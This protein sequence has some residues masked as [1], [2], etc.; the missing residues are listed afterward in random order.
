MKDTEPIEIVIKIFRHALIFFAVIVIFWLLCKDFVP[1]GKLE[2]KNDFRKKS[3]LIS[4]LYP[5]NRMKKIEQEAGVYFQVMRIDPV[6]F[7]VTTPRF[8]KTASVII[9]YQNP[10]QNLFQIGLKDVNSDW[11]FLFKTFENKE[12]NI[13]PYETE[14][15][16]IAQAD[17]KL[18]P[19]FINNNKL[20]FILSSPLLYDREGEIKIS[21]IKIIFKKE[22]WTKIGIVAEYRIWHKIINFCKFFQKLFH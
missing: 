6:Y 13:V 16:K 21:E 7:D 14:G 19:W 3:V 8:F 18:E 22:P 4:D 5:I 2:I 15:W 17:F 11:N 12:N 20:Y 1:M 9:K 10:S